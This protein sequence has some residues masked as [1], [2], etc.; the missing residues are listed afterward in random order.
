MRFEQLTD[1]KKV[2]VPC[3]HIDTDATGVDKHIIIEPF[4]YIKN[5]DLLHSDRLSEPHQHSG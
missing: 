1:D 2:V 4:Y 3:G 5:S